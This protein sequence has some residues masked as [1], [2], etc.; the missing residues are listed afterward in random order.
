M[1]WKKILVSKRSGPSKASADN[2]FL[3]PHF[4]SAVVKKALGTT[5]TCSMTVALLRI[6]KC[7]LLQT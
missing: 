6:K 7:I 4:F 1:R 3:V 2:S 5:L